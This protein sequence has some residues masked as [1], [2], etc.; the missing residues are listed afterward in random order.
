MNGVV[1]ARGIVTTFKTKC[2]RDVSLRGIRIS[3]SD[4][5]FEGITP[6]RFETAL[7]MFARRT[8]PGQSGLIVD[9]IDPKSIHSTF[10]IICE[11]ES[12]PLDGPSILQ[13]EPKRSLLICCWFLD[14]F[15]EKPFAILENKIAAIDWQ[16]NATDSPY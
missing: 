10:L 12:T 1:L 14:F 2:K 9:L 8:F 16:S 11:L 7:R 4:R 6:S 5:D 3:S 13:E 15:P